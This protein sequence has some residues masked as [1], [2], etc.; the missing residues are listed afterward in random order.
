MTR[1]HLPSLQAAAAL[2]SATP[3]DK[4]PLRLIQ[5]IGSRSGG[6]AYLATCDGKVAIRCDHP[7]REVVR[8]TT[9][10]MEPTMGEVPI[11]GTELSRDRV[12]LIWADSVPK[13]KPTK[14]DCDAGCWVD[15]EGSGI[16]HW[17]VEP[18]T[19]RFNLTQQRIPGDPHT[20][21]LEGVPDLAQLNGLREFIPGNCA[22]GLT[23]RV[24]GNYLGLLN[25]AAELLARG[26]SYRGTYGQMYGDT[27]SLEFY[28]EI[29][30]EGAP[31][32]VDLTAQRFQA[33]GAPTA[34]GLLMPIQRRKEGI[35]GNRLVEAA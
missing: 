31:V 5:V 29:L 9:I 18:G 30:R 34:W 23:G 10:G 21:Y 8:A 1:L 28:T 33:V 2:A 26:Y 35:R 14:A 22:A 16:V 12:L 3:K 24:N 11:E 32:Q 25:K 6:Q 27:A 19:R 17:V 15:L 13:K 4:A 20:S 7:C